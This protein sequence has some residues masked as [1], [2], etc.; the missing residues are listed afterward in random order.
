MGKRLPDQLVPRYEKTTTLRF[1]PGPQHNLFPSTA[2][3]ILTSSSYTVTPESN[4]MG[5]RLTGQK[6]VRKRPGHFISDCTTVG[7][8]Q[9]PD[10]GQPILLMADRQTTG[11]YP[12]IGCVITAD[13]PLAAQLAP[14][15]FITFSLTTVP[16]A[17]AALRKQ[18]ALLDAALAPTDRA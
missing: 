6:V 17:Q 3:T 8:L 15:N 7:A 14:G 4:R 18:H 1:I 2:V 16:Q 10:D 13:L 9:I 12:K 5:Y 11:G